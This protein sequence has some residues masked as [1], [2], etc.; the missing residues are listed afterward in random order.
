MSY[1]GSPPASQFFA[2][3]TDT[4]SGDGTTV[5]FT[6]SRNVGTVN[7]IL[8]VV[9]NVDQQ[10]TAYSVSVSTLTFTAAPSAGT[11][12]IYVRYLSTNLTA[13]VPQAGSIVPGNF[14]IDGNL[15]FSGSARRITGDFSNA[16]IAN[17][18]LF[19]TSTVNSST[20]VGAIANGTGTESRLSLFN[21][22][23]PANA[24]AIDI[25]STASEVMFRASWAGTGTALPMTFYTGGSERMRIDTS[26]NVGIGLSPAYKLDVLTSAT[27]RFGVVTSSGGNLIASVNETN[28]SYTNLQIASL[29]TNFIYGDVLVT[30]TFGLGYG[31]GAGGT[32]TQ[33]TS[34]ATPVTLNKPTGR[35]TMNGAA[36]AAGASAGFSFLNSLFGAADNLVVTP[37]FTSGGGGNYRVQTFAA[38]GGPLILV[39]NISAASRSDALIL[40]FVIIKGAAS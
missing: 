17:R 23:D 37:D 13:I 3:G 31:T 21:S 27:T 20:I 38:T 24:S 26:G 32:V 29:A 1:L 18:V 39:T 25:R 15:N 19:Q 40:N 36:L 22:S 12:N 7:D 4:F 10:P 33:A 8:V 11:N 5:A 14:G 28:V 9:N 35:I 2:P 6:L 30:N 34:K 16:T